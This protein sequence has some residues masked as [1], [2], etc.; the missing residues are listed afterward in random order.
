MVIFKQ[1]MI[2]QNIVEQPDYLS[3]KW[4]MVGAVPHNCLSPLQD[5]NGPLLHLPTGSQCF[6]QTATVLLEQGHGDRQGV[7]PSAEGLPDAKNR[8]E[9]SVQ[10]ILI[11]FW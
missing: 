6:T 9:G 11:S 10:F 1:K 5:N 4:L 8:V 7:I 3:E 2:L